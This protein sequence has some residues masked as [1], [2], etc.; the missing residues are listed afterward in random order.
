MLVYGGETVAATKRVLLSESCTRQNGKA[1][2]CNIAGRQVAF[3][4]VF[5]N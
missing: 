1:T 2:C 5:F 4:L 3:V